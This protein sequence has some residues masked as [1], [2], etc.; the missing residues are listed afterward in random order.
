MRDLHKIKLH[1]TQGLSG[2]NG[3]QEDGAGQA[4]LQQQSH[5]RE[6]E[7]ARA[8]STT[9]RHVCQG[10]RNR[11]WDNTTYPQ[12]LGPVIVIQRDRA[13][14]HSGVNSIPIKHTHTHRLPFTFS[15]CVQ[16]ETRHPWPRIRKTFSTWNSLQWHLFLVIYPH[17]VMR[18]AV[19]IAVPQQL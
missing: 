7:A 11:L 14:R 3:I 4:W 10:A 15:L 19:D 1:K 16:R 5:T 12:H 17:F 9:A 2:G 18:W 8:A 6:P 13:V